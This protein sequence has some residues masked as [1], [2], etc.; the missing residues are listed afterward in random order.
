MNLAGELVAVVALPPMREAADETEHLEMT[1]FATPPAGSAD[2]FMALVLAAGTPGNYH[3]VHDLACFPN[4]ER[5][6]QPRMRGTV[7][8]RVEGERV[9]LSAERIEN[10]RDAANCSGTLALELWALAAP[11]Q[12][13]TFQG[14]PIAGV[15]IGTLMGQ[16]ESTATSFELPFSR[17]PAGEWHFV[18]MLREWTAAGYVTRDFTNFN[19]PVVYASAPSPT[20]PANTLVSVEVAKVSQTPPRNSAPAVAAA[21]DSRAT[22]EPAAAKAAQIPSRVAYANEP[23]SINA[24]AAQELAKLDGI[25]PKLAQAIIR[26]RPFASVDELRKVRG[27]TLK[28]LTRIRTRLRL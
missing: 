17:P 4:P 9:H 19:L 16:T 24:A 14:V 2:H 7:S 18:M 10:P 23:V 15:V 21:G 12:G 20:P 28:L 27:I 22:R 26:K 3:E 5:F 13:G 8:Y 1:S 6:L 11:Y 25:T